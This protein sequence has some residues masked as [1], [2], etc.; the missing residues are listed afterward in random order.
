MNLKDLNIMLYQDMQALSKHSPDTYA[1]FILFNKKAHSSHML[2]DDTTSTT[3]TTTDTTTATT[4]D[5]S[6]TNDASTSTTTT[7]TPTTTNATNITTTVNMTL[8]IQPYVMT[9]YLFTL[10]ALFVVLLGGIALCSVQ[11]PD[12]FPRLPLLVGRESN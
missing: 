2:Q 12:K 9:G 4:T 3:D 5:A 10:L 6:I 11:A 7:T 8:R 1:I